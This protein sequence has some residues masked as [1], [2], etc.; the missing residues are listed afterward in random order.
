MMDWSESNHSFGMYVPDQHKL[1][2]S[3]SD[4]HLLDVLRTTA[5][6]LCHCAQQESEPLPDNAGDT[7][8]SLGERS[9][10]CGRYRHARL[11][12]QAS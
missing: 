2:V 3:L 10:C 9:K 5:H 7:G 11:C 8:S 12:Q 6:E 1:H 4:R